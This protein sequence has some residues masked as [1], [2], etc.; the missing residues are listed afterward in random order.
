LN[1][2]KNYENAPG[3]RVAHVRLLLEAVKFAGEISGQ[4]MI[5][6]GRYG[7]EDSDDGGFDV[8]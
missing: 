2:S 8:R 6:S 3:A 5:D 4:K 7:G 1:F